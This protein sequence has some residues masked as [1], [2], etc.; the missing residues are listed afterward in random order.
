[1]NKL[2]ILGLAISLSLSTAIQPVFAALSPEEISRSQEQLD[3]LRSKYRLELQQFEQM[4]T[5]KAALENTE[6][7]NWG[8]NTHGQDV[9]WSPVM[10]LAVPILYPLI[11]ALDSSNPAWLR[12][13]S[14]LQLITGLAA[15]GGG[16]A[17]YTDSKLPKGSETFNTQTMNALL[18]G[19]AAAYAGLAVVPSTVVAARDGVANSVNQERLKVLALEHSD[20]QTSLEHTQSVLRVYEDLLAD[21]LDSA[22]DRADLLS[23][24]ELKLGEITAERINTWRL[25]ALDSSLAEYATLEQAGDPESTLKHLKILL[26]NPNLAL[27]PERKT[28]LEAS[29]SKWES[30]AEKA[31][32]AR[33]KLEA[34]QAA[35][36]QAESDKIAKAELREKTFGEAYALAVDRNFSG[37]L[38]KLNEYDWQ[39]SDPEYSKV[40]EKR[41]VWFRALL[42]DAYKGAYNQAANGDVEGAYY[43]LLATSSIWPKD[44]PDYN[45]VQQK[46]K[47]WKKILDQRSALNIKHGYLSSEQISALKELRIPVVIPSELP[48]DNSWRFISRTFYDYSIPSYVII[49]YDTKTHKSFAMVSGDEYYC[50]PNSNVQSSWLHAGTSAYISNPT[51]GR[52]GLVTVAYQDAYVSKAIKRHG[53]CYAV[54]TPAT[55][56]DNLSDFDVPTDLTRTSKKDFESV[57]KSLKFLP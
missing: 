51:F 32:K 28:E 37:A 2:L 16:A 10:G 39:E 12:W 45:R 15:L 53:R 4:S 11:T 46:L 14:G 38:D 31:R 54:V 27:M 17:L 34:D 3:K 7:L 42:T 36:E 41:T 33:E 48:S 1:M 23:F 9:T 50:G 18:Y 13:T 6:M 30:A 8:N 47:D 20:L 43:L 44:H 26:E 29:L 21:K 5:E 19:G 40:N 57:I 35:R 52:V 25:A 24:H 56:F 55:Y 49:Y 22:A